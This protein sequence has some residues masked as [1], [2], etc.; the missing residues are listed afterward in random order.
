[1]GCDMYGAIIGDIVGSK[2]EFWPIKTKEFPFV[3]QGCEFTDDTVM[4]VAVARALMKTRERNHGIE[5][6]PFKALLIQ[7]MQDLGHRY[8]NTGY[9]G[10]FAKWLDAPDPR[11]YNSYGNGSAMRVSPCGL[12]AYGLDEALELA[13]ASAVVTH[14]HPEGIRGAQAVV[15]CVF[16]AKAG[17]TKGEIRSYVQDHFYALPASLDDIRPAYTFDVTCPGSVPQAIQC[18][19]ESTSYED[20]VRNAVSL[21][22]DADTQA[23]IAGAIAWTYYRPYGEWLRREGAE[24]YDVTVRPE[25][26][27]GPYEET[28]KR[29]RGWPVWC[30]MIVE[31]NGI[32][33]ILPAE[34]L[35]TIDEFEECVGMHMAAGHRMSDY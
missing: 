14:N 20:A 25:D 9:G 22:G 15:A 19:L 31:D 28:G 27:T 2:Y 7:E 21:G 4:T 35:K 10:M 11:P 1:M 8:P 26:C 23:A 29:R 17:K 12:Y 5:P 3:S 18:F 33:G 16:L 32:D 13:K 24:D 6:E 34:F 30:D